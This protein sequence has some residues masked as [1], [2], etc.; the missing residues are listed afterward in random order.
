MN[1]NNELK[2]NDM[3]KVTGLV[4]SKSR[5]GNS[6]KVNGEWYSVFSSA[7]MPAEWKDTVDFLWEPDKTG[8]YK[9][10]KKGTIKVLSGGDSGAPSG[11]SGYTPPKFNN[12]G[13]ELGHAANLAMEMTLQSSHGGEGQ[14]G[15]T[16]MYKFWMEHTDNIYK[17]M[18]GLRAK[19]E[20]APKVEAAKVAAVEA[21]KEADPR[22]SEDASTADIF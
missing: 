2:G 20:D 5:K 18:K 7:D 1:V 6:I 10:I 17:M 16:E 22:F 12:L 3:E 21:T 11:S 14:V 9:N 13:V 19:Y 4:E 8:A 15:S